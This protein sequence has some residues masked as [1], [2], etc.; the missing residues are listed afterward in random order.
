MGAP[1]L[2][3]VMH[4]YSTAASKDVKNTKRIEETKI[5]IATYPTNSQDINEI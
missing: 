5:I 4:A 1:M 3:D 2:H